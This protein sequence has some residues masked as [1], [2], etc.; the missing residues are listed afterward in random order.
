M[1]ELACPKCGSERLYKAGL[2]YL[3][4][5]EEVQ[6]WLCRDTGLRFT[7]RK[8]PESATEAETKPLYCQSGY[9]SYRR[10]CELLQESKN[11]TENIPQIV[12]QREGTLKQADVKGRI[13]EYAWWLQ[14][15][16][17]SQATIIGRSKLIAVLAKRGADLYDPES[18]K[19]TIAKQPWCE[20]RKAN[21]VDAYS[22]FLKMAGGK[23]EP[24]R[25]KSIRKIPFIPTETE[26]DQLIAACSSRI[27]TFLQLLKETGIRPGEAWQLNW[28]DI[29]TATKTVRIT[30]EKG[31]NPRIFALSQKL[32][33]MLE[34]LPKIYGKRV[35]SHPDMPLDHHRDAYNQ[36]RKRIANK[37]KNPRLAEITFK[38]LRHW[39][40]TME[41]HRTKDVL[42][43]METLG[44]KNIKNTLVYVHLAEALFK[45]QQE[46]VSKVAKSETDACALVDAGFEYVCDFNQNKIFRKR[47]Y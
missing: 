38:T 7:P 42:H 31:S 36:Q 17:Y 19:N 26:I 8:K 20:G 10:V 24:P 46:Y 23:W 33:Q 30:P 27:G 25:Y 45:D 9:S 39:K 21:A 12:A 1:S 29:D 40:G 13:I 11:L 22:T 37:L 43:V 6:R 14:K 5:G 35:F 34:T 2:R 47:K 4:D 28:T 44:H 15:E 32:A 41:Y 3:S 18:V 16:G